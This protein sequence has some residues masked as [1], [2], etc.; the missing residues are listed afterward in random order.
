MENLWLEFYIAQYWQD[1]ARIINLL[2]E[3]YNAMVLMQEVLEK[4]RLEEIKAN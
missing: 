1:S 3:V 4:C 2:Q